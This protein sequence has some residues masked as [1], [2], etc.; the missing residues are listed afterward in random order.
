MDYAAIAKGAYDN[1]TFQ[2]EET[3]TQVFII[4][5]VLAFRG[6]SNMADWRTNLKF[7][8]DDIKGYKAH[9]GFCEAWASVRDMVCS[10]LAVSSTRSLHITGHSLGGGVANVAAIDLM[11]FFPSIRLVTF[12]CPRVFH[13]NT[14]WPDKVVATRV[15][16]NNDVVPRLPFRA[17][18]YSHFGECIYFDHE[19]NNAKLDGWNLFL[20]RIQGRFEDLGRLHTDAVNDHFMDEYERLCQNLDFDAD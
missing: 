10:E 9:R 4:D 15:V 7:A 5:G 19:G 13:K 12:G 20:D 18:G 11:E 6:S 1:F 3:D 2:S 14:I 8:F 16:N 17:A